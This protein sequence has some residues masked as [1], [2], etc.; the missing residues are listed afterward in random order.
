[1]DGADDDFVPGRGHLLHQHAVHDGIRRSAGDS[2]G[3]R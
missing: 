2:V 3:E 1:M